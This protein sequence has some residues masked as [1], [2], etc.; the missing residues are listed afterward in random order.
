MEEIKKFNVP[1]IFFTQKN[2]AEPP[3]FLYDY[4]SNITQEKIKVSLTKN[5]FSFV[6]EGVKKI[7]LPQGLGK[8][9]NSAFVLLKK[10]NGLMTEKVSE[11]QKYRSIL[12]SFDDEILHTFLLKYQFQ[13]ENISQEKDF[14]ILPKDDFILNFLE[15]LFLQGKAIQDLPLSLKMLKFEELMYYLMQQPFGK[16]VIN[17]LLASQND[18]QTA[19]F[20]NIIEANINNTLTIS[21][22]AFLCNMSIS[23]F[24]R[25][26]QEIY[27]APPNKWFQN[28]RLEK[29]AFLLKN[30]QL[31]P[32]DIYFEVGFSNLSSFI[33]AFK[34]K[35]GITP[36]KFMQ[37]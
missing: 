14:M 33:Q 3:I 17:F 32:S 9:D 2:K 35:Y 12:F 18:K 15:S 8:I 5:L 20:K 23:T 29:A 25:K 26:F 28:K 21:E 34:N 13:K 37:I 19:H 31:R 16:R 7:I 4:S 27:A 30:Q 36:K 1:D 11:S 6:R 10:G 22:L 24:K